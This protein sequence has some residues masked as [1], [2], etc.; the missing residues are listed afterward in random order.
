MN[1]D[2]LSF[3]CLIFPEYYCFG[4]Q[5]VE[6]DSYFFE[7]IDYYYCYYLIAIVVYYHFVE[8]LVVVNQAVE[9][10]IFLPNLVVLEFYYHLYFL[11]WTSQL[12]S[13]RFVLLE[14]V[15][16]IVVLPCVV[17]FAFLEYFVVVQESVV[18][19]QMYLVFVALTASFVVFAVSVA[20]VVFVVFDA[21]VVTVVFAAQLVEF[22]LL[23]FLLNYL[24]LSFYLYPYLDLYLSY[25]FSFYHFVQFYHC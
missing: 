23:Q 16:M 14:F 18:S 12:S 8:N 24:Y 9:M 10:M 7:Q 19:S 13:L 15:E 5:I 20:S 2:Y 3:D 11:I 4:Y 1:F 6:T 17:E 22:C 25:H 21:L